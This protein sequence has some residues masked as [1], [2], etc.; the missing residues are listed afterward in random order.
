MSREKIPVTYDVDTELISAEDIEA[1]LIAMKKPK[2]NVQ[3]DPMGRFVNKI[4]KKV[5]HPLAIIVN[6]IIKGGRWP[7]IWKEEEGSLIPKKTMP[8]SFGELRNV[9]CTSIFSKLA[10]TYLLDRLREETDLEETQFGGQKGSSTEHLLTELVTDQM[11]FLEDNWAATTMI[12][13]DLE[14]AF[15]RMNH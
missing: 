14:K 11:Q 8:E 9:S 4:A 7:A 5:S 2:S 13:I 6:N 3:I 10:E 1:Q 15:N 12:S